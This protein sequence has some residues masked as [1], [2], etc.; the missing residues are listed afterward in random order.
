MMEIWKAT[1][2]AK[3]GIGMSWLTI[4]LDIAC[5]QSSQLTSLFIDKRVKLFHVCCFLLFYLSLATYNFDGNIRHGLPLDIGDAVQIF[6]S[7]AGMK[8]NHNKC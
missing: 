6:E 7:C 3:Y 5:C 8:H 1:E 2:G 4:L